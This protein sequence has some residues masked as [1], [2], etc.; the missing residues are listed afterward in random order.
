MVRMAGIVFPGNMLGQQDLKTALVEAS[1]P[2][3]RPVAGD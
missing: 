1:N 2:R 3:E